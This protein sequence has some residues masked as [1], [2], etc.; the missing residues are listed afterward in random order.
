MA[1]AGAKPTTRVVMVEVRPRSVM[2]V[3]LAMGVASS[4]SVLVA[5]ACLIAVAKVTGV[6]RPGRSAL[7]HGAAQRA[8]HHVDVLLYAGIG[9][10]I[11][12]L[13]GA[14]VGGGMVALFANHV[15]PLAGGV[16]IDEEDPAS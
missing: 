5:T 2:R 8:P 16:A 15:L 7:H 11:V 4:V 1:D 13:V 12:T 10:A 6:H 3:A 14:V 9:L